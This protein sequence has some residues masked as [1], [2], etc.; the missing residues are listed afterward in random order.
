MAEVR[1][2]IK[3][4]K[5]LESVVQFCDKS[6]IYLSLDLFLSDHE[7]CQALVLPLLHPL[8]GIVLASAFYAPINVCLKALHKVDLC[9]RSLPKKS[10]SLEILCSYIEPSSL[11]PS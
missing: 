4:L 6:M 2:Q 9:V 8:H 1:D 3:I 7:P 11:G 5:C 10:N